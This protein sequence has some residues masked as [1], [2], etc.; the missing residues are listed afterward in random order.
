[1]GR[2]LAAVDIGSNTAHI[3]VADT[4]KGTLRKIADENVW[5][6]LGEIVARKGEIPLG[7]QD[8]LI[9]ALLEFKTLAKSSRAKGI[10]IFAT[11]A[12]RS[13]SNREAVLKRVHAE[14]GVTVDLVAA[15]QEALY[16]IKGAMLDTGELAEMIFVEVGGGSV[17]VAQALN[18]VMVKDVSLR[19]GSG[20]LRASHLTN[21][22]PAEKEV[23]KLERYIRHQLEENVEKSDTKNIVSCGG[24]ARGLWRC[25]HPD[26]D[27]EIYRE[28]LE[29]LIWATSR[30]DL[31]TLVARFGVKPRRAATILPGALVFREL[32]N[33]FNRPSMVV[34]RFG[35][36]EGAILEMAEERIKPCPI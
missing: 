24:I 2:V 5:L 10:Y 7:V 14:V 34:S 1:M 29:Y 16:G 20:T 4:A 18:G 19:L 27:R 11:E 3:L 22:P 35:V 6:N 30:L 15:D 25:V 32:L 36:R 33:F 13:A 26:G 28:E 17:Q 12:I 23:V 8:S 21:Y 31:D 9:G